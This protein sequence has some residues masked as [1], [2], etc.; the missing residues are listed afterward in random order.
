MDEPTASLSAHEVGRLFRIVDDAA[1]SRASPC[2]SS[3]TAW[4]R[5]SRSPTAS[6]SCATASWISDLAA[7]RGDARRPRSATWSAA[8]SDDFFKRTRAV[9]GEVV[10]E[11]RGLGP[12]GRLLGRHVQL[13]RR[14]SA[15]ICRARRRRPHRCRPRALRRLSRAT[16]GEILL[17]G[18]A[19]HRSAAAP[20]RTEPRHRLHAP[21]IAGSS[22]WCCR[23]SIAAN[24]SLPSLRR[25][26]T[27]LGLVRR[28]PERA[29]AAAFTAPAAHP[30]GHRWT[31]RRRRCR[32]ATSRRSCSSK[33][34]ERHAAS[35]DP[36]RADPRHRRRR[37]GGGPPDHRRPGCTRAWRSS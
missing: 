36:G 18:Q 4:R 28:A 22:A 2:S 17:D 9:P 1:A 21:R 14:R 25:Y 12:G 29:T 7:R 16:A 19:G 11:V 3:P 13:S 35:A 32:A 24:I 6:R 23:M 20:G 8:A 37:Q 5:S 26:L 33:W 10:L 31:R 27:R 34:L 30:R 15:G